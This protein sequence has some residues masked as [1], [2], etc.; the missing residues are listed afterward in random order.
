[1]IDSNI[2]FGVGINPPTAKICQ[3]EIARIA[4]RDTS[5]DFLLLLIL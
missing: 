4:V 3:S 2:L 5:S 1:M